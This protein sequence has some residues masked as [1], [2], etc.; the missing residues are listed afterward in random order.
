MQN[1][2]TDQGIL[3]VRVLS[4]TRF[5]VAINSILGQLGDGVDGSIFADDLAIY[6]TIRNQKVAA[7]ALQGFT[8][9]LDAW[10][11]ESLSLK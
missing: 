1:K 11:V 2:R 6:I 4:V 10:A 7:R 5:L 3:M 8:N 9:N